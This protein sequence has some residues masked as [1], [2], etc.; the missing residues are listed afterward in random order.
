MTEKFEAWKWL[1]T[2]YQYR[3]S[4]KPTTGFA[5]NKDLISTCGITFEYC[6]NDTSTLLLK[7]LFEASI[8]AT[9]QK[10]TNRDSHPIGLVTG[11][12]G[13]GKTRFLLECVN[14]IKKNFPNFFKDFVDL[15]IISYSNANIPNNLDLELGE[16]K[17]L[18]L[19]FLHSVFVDPIR[20][21]V[22]FV[23]D[24]K[25]AGFQYD[26]ITLR[27]AITIARKGLNIQPTSNWL[28]VI[29]IDEF[30]K[31]ITNFENDR[32]HKFLSK[33]SQILGSV[34]CNPPEYT[35]VLGLMAGTMATTINTVFR[36]SSHLTMSMRLSPLS[37]NERAKILMMLGF[38]EK[39]KTCREFRLSLADVGGLP[40]IFEAFVMECQPYIRNNIAISGWPFKERI[41]PAVKNY[42]HTRYLDGARPFAVK[43]IEDIIL[44]TPVYRENAIDTTG[45]IPTTYGELESQA[46]VL[47]IEQDDKSCIVTMPFLL[48]EWLLTSASCLQNPATALLKKLFV[49]GID[50][51]I[52]WQEFEVFVA[53]FETSKTMLMYQ[54]EKRSS[55]HSCITINLS[56]YFKVEHD[57]PDIILPQNITFC[58]S[59]ER[60]PRNKNIT[61]SCTGRSIN[62]ECETSPTIING[63]SAEFA[64]IF[65]V[66]MMADDLSDCEER[67]DSKAY[68][69]SK[70]IPYLCGS[71]NKYFLIC[72]QCNLYS[73]NT[74]ISKKDIED[75]IQKIHNAITTYLPKYNNRWLLVIYT[76]RIMENPVDDPRCIVIDSV[77]MEE[78]FSKT[79]VERAIH[80]LEH[81][82]VNINYFDVI[83]LKQARGVGTKYASMIVEERKR[84]G[85]FE[86]WENL[87]RRINCIPDALYDKFEY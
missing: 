62:W 50:K 52:T 42:A 44:Q 71:F 51:K 36:E 83:E 85:S 13:I 63:N 22:D 80:L 17:S 33:I 1:W 25:E 78:H 70:F 7:K 6:L 20:A 47:L 53:I 68:F 24:L 87:K 30:N 31:I 3:R 27:E 55:N 2:Q 32:G 48:L 66:R 11:A 75:E 60:F 49:Y 12:P 81:R 14:H 40:R 46:D 43:L 76:T 41:I 23:M 79:L 69:T 10:N 26:D 65:T 9:A 74:N 21:Y 28:L 38:P 64:D 16:N 39:W 86:N 45:N 35:T 15:V 82:K 37:E 77:K 67:D 19:R 29:S 57:F 54:H 84:G 61:D 56:D 59:M 58:K 73:S 34:M 72:G 8:T 5:L 4:S 18:S